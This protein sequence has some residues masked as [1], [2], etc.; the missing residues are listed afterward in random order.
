VYVF[1]SVPQTN[2]KTTSTTK[3]FMTGIEAK[4]YFECLRVFNLM[5]MSLFVARWHVQARF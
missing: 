5:L 1:A 3:Y 2:E 4:N